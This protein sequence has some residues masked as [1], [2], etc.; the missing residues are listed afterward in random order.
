[1]GK[2]DG[3][4]AIVTG[5]ASGIGRGMAEAF[6]A[7]G[8]TGIT[9][10]DLNEEGATT[11]AATC[12][13]AGAGTLV[14]R[15]D[16]TSEDDWVRVVS[17]TKATFGGRIDVCCNNAGIATSSLVKDMSLELWQQMI[18]VDLTSVFLGCRAVLPTMLEQDYGRI[19]NTGSQLGLRGAATVAH[20]CAAKGGV[21]ALSK[22]LAYEVADTGI[23]VNA[24]AP[25]PTQT[26]MLA[27]LPE[28]D[29]R[30]D[31]TRGAPGPI[32]TDRRDRPDGR[33]S[34]LRGRWRLLPWRGHECLGWTRHVVAGGS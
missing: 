31:S 27:D 21:H 12:A 9:L 4:V 15:A 14:V 28:G 18:D 13:D 5:G 17:E 25:G 19:I 16:V 11:T 24:L 7:E 3:R 30:G 10:V 32:R 23:R 33:P 8:C 1:M 29:N 34:R 20:Y 6:A 2:L 22:S 26:E